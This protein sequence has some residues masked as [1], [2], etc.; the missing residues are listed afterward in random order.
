MARVLV[1]GANS[2]LAT[3]VIIELLE[4]GHSVKGLLRNI[5]DFQGSM[6]SGLELIGGNFTHAETAMRA[7][8]GC[9][10]VIHAAAVTRQD[11]TGYSEYEHVNVKATEYLVRLCIA[12]HVRRFA[13]VSSANAFGYG[14]KKY[15]G[16]E[17][18]QSRFPFTKSH[19]AIS[20]SEGQKA[21]LSYKDNIEIVVV[22]PTF[23]IGKYD[24]KPG[25]GRIIFMGYRKKIIFYPPGGKNFIHAR[26]AARGTVDAM[27]KGKNG[28]A[29]VLASENL[30]FKA[31]F[32]KLS[33]VTG[34]NP[35]YVKI[36]RSILSA[37][38]VFGS[39]LRFLGIRTALSAVNMR[40]LSVH[41]Y[42]S[43]KKSC[44]ELGLR[45]SSVEQAIADA[46]NWFTEKGMLKKKIKQQSRLC[47]LS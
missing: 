46:V 8:R 40:I 33:A 44:N 28:E 16:N 31:F 38:G 18:T 37:L 23:I 43:N 9:E 21:V 22:N 12:E 45:L 39:F 36:P 41:N 24:S 35:V 27:E 3:H 30:T 15:P 6:H 17:N 20:K 10:F 2:L 26:D 29:Y 4:R 32:Q 47:A 11:L 1:T 14:T 34:N 7:I 5:H 19:Y 25:S 42:Y 13:Y